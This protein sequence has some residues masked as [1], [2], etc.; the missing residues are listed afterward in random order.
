MCLEGT[1][2]IILWMTLRKKVYFMVMIID[3]KQLCYRIEKSIKI[4]ESSNFIIIP[5][6]K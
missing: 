1:K 4:Y 6:S 5:M 3:Y 2:H